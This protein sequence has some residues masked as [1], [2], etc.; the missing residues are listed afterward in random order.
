MFI[1]ETSLAERER[2]SNLTLYEYYFCNHLIRWER[3]YL[4]QALMIEM[5]Q[6]TIQFGESYP[7]N[8]PGTLR[9]SGN[10]LAAA[11]LDVLYKLI[12]LPLA[13]KTIQES[14]VLRPAI[15]QLLNSDFTAEELTTFGHICIAR[16]T[17]GYWGSKKNEL[18][19]QLI[20]YGNRLLRLPVEVIPFTPGVGKEYV[21]DLYDIYHAE[22][23]PR[24]YKKYAEGCLSALMGI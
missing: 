12:N 21:S 15:D 5:I 16:G 13:A 2:Y 7:F 3:G 1:D 18:A 4:P 17:K 8:V 11:A 19:A 23:L 10:E 6:K 20:E 22:F 9:R 24:F 14:S